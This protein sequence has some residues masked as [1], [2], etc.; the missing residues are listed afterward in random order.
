MALWMRGSVSFVALREMLSFIA[1][2]PDGVRPKEMKIWAREQARLRTRN[3]K[4]VSN[5]TIY[6]Y[7]NTLRHLGIVRVVNGRYQVAKE[8]SLVWDLLQRL[9]PGLPE[10]SLPER[11]LFAQFVVRNQDCQRYFFNLFMPEGTED[12]DLEGFLRK[13]TPVVWRRVDTPQGPA[14]E[15]Y[16]VAQ[17]EKK[18]WIRSE[19][20]RQAILYGVRYWARNELG[21]I[22]E[23]YL[24]GMGGLMF[25]VH[26][27]GPI[28]DPHI[29]K[30]LREA[31]TPEEEW[32]VFSLRKLAITWGPNYR[33]S[34][35]R[36]YGTLKWVY[37][38][39]PQHVV[40]IPTS[41]AFATITATSS[42]AEMY[43]LRGYLQ[44]DKGRYISH[45]RVH[46][47]LREAALWPEIMPV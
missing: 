20:E 40:L 13:G 12:Y 46:R 32:T 9:Q 43:H 4:L 3:G 14:E 44:D 34:L 22:D 35:E 23:I 11:E 47:K 1:Q 28:P 38:H 36:L 33:I 25:P 5:T 42:Q 15:I 21:F 6:H 7:R 24:E 8:T 37:W 39:F 41:E 31:L 2:H 10:L 18:R 17:T 16:N 45:I 19:D 30:A 29:L 27:N 26:L